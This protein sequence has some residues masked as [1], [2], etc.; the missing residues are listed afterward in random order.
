MKIDHFILIVYSYRP[1][2]L[3]LKTDASKSSFPDDMVSRGLSRLI[4]LK[5]PSDDRKSGM[6]AWTDIPAPVAE[7]KQVIYDL[8]KSNGPQITTIRFAFMIARIT[9]ARWLTEFAG[10][11]RN[12]GNAGSGDEGFKDKKTV[13]CEASQ[14]VEKTFGQS[15]YKTS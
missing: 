10:G 11:T 12:V 1:S 8:E 9:R 3:T 15:S 6:P 7:N 5:R 14:R 4:D 13:I 2:L